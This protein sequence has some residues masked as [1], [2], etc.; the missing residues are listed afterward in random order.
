MNK[1][2]YLGHILSADGVKLD[3]SKI[4]AIVKMP[5]PTCRKDFERFLGMVNYV[6]KYIPGY[7]DKTANLRDLLKKESVWHWDANSEKLFQFLRRV[8]CESPVLGC[9]D[10][11]KPVTLCVDASSV[12][13]GAAILQENK[14][15]AYA[16]RALTETQQKYAQIE[17]EMLAIDH[18]CEKLHAYLYNRPVLVER[19]IINH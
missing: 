15:I 7:S 16:S 1:I 2:T 13:L 9:F 8:L 3:E 18:G 5:S 10:H 17:K 4:E 14:P 19:Q 6:S 11:T 12:G